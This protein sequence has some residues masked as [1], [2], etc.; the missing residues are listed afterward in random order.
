M[1]LP[2]SPSQTPHI[3]GEPEK[4]AV[5][6]LCTKPAEISVQ[7][8]NTTPNKD[9]STRMP[10][11]TD[12]KNGSSH[13][14]STDEKAV[15]KQPS[16]DTTPSD[17]SCIQKVIAPPIGSRIE[18]LWRV[19]YD[20]EEADKMEVDTDTGGPQTLIRWWGA[21]VQ[22]CLSE[23][24]GSKCPQHADKKVFV[25]L[26]DAFQEFGEDTA[27]VA[28]ISHDC[29]VDLSQLDDVNKGELEWRMENAEN[30]QAETSAEDKAQLVSLEQ[31]ANEVSA[32]V[33]GA[34][35]SEEA[36]LQILNSLPPHVQAQVA[37]GYRRF[38]D[39]VKN[40]LASFME[41]KPKDYIV[42][43]AD[44]QNMFAS[45]DTKPT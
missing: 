37:S 17:T 8:V 39:H 22:D 14:P 41:E 32:A 3:S 18:V 13:P 29:L 15:E 27:T 5:P 26:Y 7:T 1:S 36:D 9:S 42:T 33:E 12:V 25:L 35:L 34:G 2:N 38:A 23:T 21:T 11:P 4:Q 20:P 44:V 40:S 30:K 19:D 43:K 6:L 24:V 16:C 45:M 28:F 10:S 31:Y